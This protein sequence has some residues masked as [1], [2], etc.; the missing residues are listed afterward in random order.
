MNKAEIMEIANKLIYAL[1]CCEDEEFVDYV[2][3]AVVSA[4]VFNADEI[5]DARGEGE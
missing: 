1:W 2:I 4:N 3:D 5:A